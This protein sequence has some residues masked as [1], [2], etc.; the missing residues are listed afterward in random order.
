MY[1]YLI[2]VVTARNIYCQVNKVPPSF[3][4]SKFRTTTWH[5]QTSVVG[6]LLTA[7]DR[8]SRLE[9]I[10]LHI[11][12]IILFSNSILPVVCYYSHIILK[13]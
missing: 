4:D 3:N 5:A 2:A 10:M 12:A 6:Y 7:Q 1:N 11:F 8:E 9:I 13:L